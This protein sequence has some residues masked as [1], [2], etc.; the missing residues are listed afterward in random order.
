MPPA[1]HCPRCK[2]AFSLF[3]I[4]RSF[5]CHHCGAPLVT[6][7]WTGVLVFEVLSLGL[8][9]SVIAVAWFGIGWPAAVVAFAGLI[10]LEV[11]VRRSLLTVHLASGMTND[12][13]AT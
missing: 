7:G 6:R 8:G 9:V 2:G 12:Q 4:G 11:Y 13:Q 5:E 1:L 3:D 10:A